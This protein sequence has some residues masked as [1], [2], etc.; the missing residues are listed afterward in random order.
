MILCA[1]GATRYLYFHIATQ[2][3]VMNARPRIL[4]RDLRTD[5]VHG[6]SSY[7]SSVS[8]RVSVSEKVQQSLQ[9]E[10][11]VSYG[12]SEREK[13]DI[14]GKDGT[15]QGTKYNLLSGR[16]KCNTTTILQ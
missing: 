16:Y 6:A 5:T 9:C 3:S 13:Y 10:L 7:A 8:G 12:S 2:L 11:D 15:S 14:I 1:F 4:V